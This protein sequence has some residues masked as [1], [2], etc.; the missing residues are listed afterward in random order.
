MVNIT[1]F[2]QIPPYEPVVQ[3]LGGILPQSSPDVLRWGTRDLAT[4]PAIGD[5]VHCR[6]NSIGEC[7]VTGYF[8]DQGF[9]GVE[10]IALH[11]PLW[12]IKQ[13]GAVRTVY[14]FGN[15]ICTPAQWAKAVADHKAKVSA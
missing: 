9:L 1:V 2:H 11:P 12:F 8:E 7:R 13:N 15:E 10:A 6:V 3:T 14:L 5:T 4:P